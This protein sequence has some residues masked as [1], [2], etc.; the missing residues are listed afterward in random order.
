MWYGGSITGRIP[1]SLCV[2]AWY[3]TRRP[4]RPGC[5]KAAVGSAQRVPVRNDFGNVGDG[6]LLHQSLR[7]SPRDR[8]TKLAGPWT[9]THQ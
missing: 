5:G 1:S 8:R 7:G 6:D 9:L 2:Q 4:G 3:F